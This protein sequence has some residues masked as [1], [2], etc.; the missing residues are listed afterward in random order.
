MNTDRNRIGI[1]LLN[2][3]GTHVVLAPQI[4]GRWTLPR[5]GVP[6]HQA[7]RRTAWQTFYEMTGLSRH[8]FVAEPF[9]TL[10]LPPIF[11]NDTRYSQVW[12]YRLAPNFILRPQKGAAWMPLQTW[13]MLP[14][15]TFT[16]VAMRHLQPVLAESVYQKRAQLI[17][18]QQALQAY[19]HGM[20]YTGRTCPALDPLQQQFGFRLT[21]E[22]RALDLQEVRLK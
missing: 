2:A 19:E 7:H 9:Y 17:K 14:H 4:C 8:S 11:P 10:L 3:S 20:P 5:R 15:N 18:L 1:C 13:C 22:W 6:D 21:S 12:C 16:K